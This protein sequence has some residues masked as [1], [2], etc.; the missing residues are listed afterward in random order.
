ML[1]RFLAALGALG[2]SAS[3]Y[4]SCVV[5]PVSEPNV[6]VLAGAGAVAA[7]L[8]WRIKRRR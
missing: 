5:I 1:V 2:L 7:V 4:A 3:A 6:V 8:A